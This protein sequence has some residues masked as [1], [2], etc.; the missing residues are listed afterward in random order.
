[1][2]A[3]NNIVS[4]GTHHAKGAE[5]LSAQNKKAIA[6]CRVIL[7][8]YLPKCFVFLGDL[9]DTLFKLA[10]Q[11]KKNLEQSEHFNIMRQLRRQQSNLEN[12]FTQLVLNDFDDFFSVS[13]NAASSNTSPKRGWKLS[14][15][16]NDDLEEEIAITRIAIKSKDVFGNEFTQLT[17]RF[18]HL[19][20]AE[21]I[22]KNPLAA[23]SIAGHFND[24]TLPI[25]SDLAIKL[26]A[27]KQFEQHAISELK[28]LCLHLNDELIKHQILPNLTH[29]NRSQ[30]YSAT[31]S[32][33]SFAESTASSSNRMTN[34][35]EY[36]PGASSIFDQLPR[37]LDSDG[38]SQT[39]N[40]SASS[41]ELHRLLVEKLQADAQSLSHDDEETINVIA[42]LFGF[43]LEDK[44]IPAPI[45]KIMARLQIPIL[46]I[47]IKDKKFFTT[48]NHPAKRLLNNLAKISTGWHQQRSGQQ[49]L[50]HNKI[51][52]VVT[53]ILS[54]FDTEISLFEEQNIQLK[55]FIEQQTQSS[56][57]A[58]QRTVKENEGQ[59]K[60]IAA[61]QEVNRVI[62]ERLSPYSHLPKVVISLIDDGWKHILRL[63]LLQ[64]GL[65]SPEWTNSVK[66]LEQLIWSVLPKPDPNDRKELLQ[67]IPHLVKELKSSLGGASFNQ[68]KI[69]AHLEALQTC[70][71]QCVNGDNLQQE[72]LQAFERRPEI[73][74]IIKQ[75]VL[76]LIPAKKKIIS[77]EDALEKASTLKVGTWLEVSGEDFPRQIKLSWRSN[78]TGQCLL[79]SY[80]GLKEA[81]LSLAELASLF[82]KGQAD[83]IDQF[84]SLMDRAH[85]SMMSA[86]NNQPGSA[87]N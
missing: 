22:S 53:T 9:D 77:D 38:V 15:L 66:L 62:N 82:Q 71:I 13:I 34:Q 26:H 51:E 30:Q 24:V 44:V 45:R 6:S 19:I 11:D 61:Q 43:I 54:E 25:T 87:E 76:P 67:T 73:N 52:T 78:L 12:E 65:D 7:T 41:L 4:F 2:L 72:V 50:I 69:R 40:G 60:L 85:V 29:G 3:N 16:N 49:D 28:N 47:A 81:D 36:V 42:L 79:V 5:E 48:K 8:D 32:T 74:N 55:Q 68:A 21:T 83:I 57:V 20:N 86:I 33:Q 80:H 18:A 35:A 39:Q 64:K 70:H 58:E 27:Y 75:E 63:R 14:I 23:T 1:M 84:E 31:P 37:S 17:R 10:E 56:I 46:K 59:E